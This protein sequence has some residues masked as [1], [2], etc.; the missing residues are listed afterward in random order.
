MAT[1]SRLLQ[2]IGFFCKRALYKRWDSAKET[3]NFEEPTNRSHPI[4]KETSYRKSSLTERGGSTPLSDRGSVHEWESYSI[5]IHTYTHAHTCRQSLHLRTERGVSRIEVVCTSERTIHIHTYTHTHTCRQSYSHTHIR[6]HTHVG[7]PIHIHTYTH[8]HT[9]TC[10][11]SYPH[12][13]IHSHTH[14][15]SPIHIHTYTHT[16]M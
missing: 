14:V 6:S 12:T 1:I 13:H 15:G 9:H 5:H 8:T 4:Q 10:R 11:Q 3:F 16:H 2:I 7:S